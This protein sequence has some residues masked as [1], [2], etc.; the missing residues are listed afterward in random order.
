LQGSHRLLTKVVESGLETLFLSDVE[1][2]E[3]NF[4]ILKGSIS[5]KT[6]EIEDAGNSSR[7][8]L[9]TGPSEF[10]INI[11]ELTK[12]RIR[13]EEMSLTEVKWDF[14]GVIAKSSEEEIEDTYLNSSGF[15]DVLALG[16]DEINY[17]SLLEQQK[18]NLNSLNL[19]DQGN[20]EI[21]R[22][23]DKWE[24][25]YSEKN[26]EI[27]DLIG[28][29]LALKSL[30][31]QDIASL[32]DARS[33]SEDLAD[34]YMRVGEAKEE[35]LTL[36]TDFQDDKA[37]LTNLQDQIKNAVDKDYTYLGELLDL[38]S[39]DMGSL[40]SGLAENY[41]R[42][43]WNTYYDNALKALEIY[44][45]FQDREPEESNEEKVL[46]RAGGRD[47]PF[48]SP[49]NPSFIIEHIL[50]S[51]G[52]DSTGS[53]GMEIRSISNEPDKLSEPLTFMAEL[54]NK[55]SAIS[56]DGS[57]DMRSDSDT[58]FSMKI[59]SPLNPILLDKGIP[60]L[61][62]SRMNAVA[63]I[64]G[65]SLTIKDK[66]IVLTN[67]DISLSALE[68]EQ[69]D[70]D[71]IISQ[72]IKDLLDDID[73]IDLKAE[74]FVSP[75]G[76]EDVN[77]WSGFDDIFADS[78]GDYLDEL[79]EDIQA[80]LQESFS[81]YIT[82]FF[83]EN[84]VLQSAVTALDI[85]SVEQISSV[86]DLENILDN[87]QKE[88]ESKSSSITSGLEADVQSQLD[89]KEAQ[90]QAEADKAKAEADKAKAE[91]EKQAQDEAAKLLENATDKIKLPGF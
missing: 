46:V 14:D 20:E 41:I 40:A 3:L 59:I 23:T 38:S 11:A 19:I 57:L 65:E 74:I 56:L 29:I 62:I 67:F 90:A 34:M 36:Q 21:S 22:L 73:N 51:G 18:K 15:F 30:S 39:G 28:D 5:Y 13:I 44:N 75:E 55:Q 24:L 33:A 60:F 31:F 16:S 61:N 48:I 50:I 70:V 89:E 25:V 52:N 58:P 71:S 63:D 47:I 72:T 9:E 45:K 68:I 42:K 27:D 17:E 1:I 88:L 66:S 37:G 49:D 12:K 4:S 64:M 32:E 76:L 2:N 69:T 10:R 84:E 54:G 6:L 80:E 53:L 91:A 83:E 7:N 77:V 87:K 35:L 8:L 81:A 85:E 78:I 82:P 86:E 79:T 43:R 26:K